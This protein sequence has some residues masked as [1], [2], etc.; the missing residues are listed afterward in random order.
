MSIKVIILTLKNKSRSE[1]IKKLIDLLYPYFTIEIY[2]GIDGSKIEIRDSQR[3]NH[4]KLISYESINKLYNNKV[5]MNGKEMKK[6]EFGASWSHLSIY[7]KLLN[8]KLYDSYLIF[9]DDAQF[10]GEIEYF[11][12]SIEQI[13]KNFDAIH[14]ALSDYL[15]FERK[16]TIN[17]YFYIPEKIFFNRLTSYIISKTGAKKLLDMTLNFINIPADD[18]VSMAYIN[19][20]F[21]LYVPNNYFFSHN[22]QEFSSIISEI[23]LL[24]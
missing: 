8:D 17:D 20:D 4:I 22:D 2:Y 5:R 1:N 12:K 3:Y 11:L 16:E 19:T 15:P 14:L 18:L 21:N 10:I 7:E 24:E 13:P 6:G 23:N 9:E